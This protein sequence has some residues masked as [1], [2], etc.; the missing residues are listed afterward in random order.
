MKNIVLACRTLKDEV[1]LVV[2]ELRVKYPIIWVDSGLHNYPDQL[3]EALQSQIDK[4]ANVDNILL[5]FGNCGNALLGIRSDIASLIFPKV[6]DC[7]SLFLGGNEQKKA[8]DREAPS[9][10]LTKG[11]FESETTLWTEYC[12]CVNK[13][14]REKSKIIFDKI[15]SKYEKLRLIKTGAYKL[16]DIME[17]TLKMA[18]ELG[19]EH[20]IV[21]GSLR[22]V[23]KAFKGEWDEEF[24]IIEPG[25]NVNPSDLGLD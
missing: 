21:T 15:L 20:E 25:K 23:Y 12:Y 9:Y 4:I 10:Y 13:Y 5:L 19:L 16:Q 2:K 11:Y 3:K 1:E 14:G 22:K 7:I 17:K 6:D 8:L 24:C 18:L